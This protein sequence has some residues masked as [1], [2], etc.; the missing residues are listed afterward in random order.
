MWKAICKA[1]L[2]V[3]LSG[4]GW[5]VAAPAMTA[6]GAVAGQRQ[7]GVDVYRGIPF[8]LPPL[9]A[10][11]WR[12]PQPV[13]AWQGVREAGKFAPACMQQGV[14]M[15]G[16]AAPTVSEDC[17]YLNIWAPPR[18]AGQRLPVIVWIHGGGYTNGS[19][20]MPLYHG[21]RLARKGVLVVTIAYRLGALGFLAHPALSAESPHRSSGNYGLMDQ[22][23]ALEWVQRN[24]AAFGGDPQR[25]TIAGQSAGAMAVSALLVSP[26]AKG[27]FQRAIAQSGGIFE[28]LQLA[29]GYLLANAER[30]GVAYMQALGATTP[31]AM[32]K[33]PAARLTGTN[34]VSHPVIDGDVLPLSPY[35]GYVRGRNHDVPLLIGSNSE[36]A[37][38]L[39]DVTAVRADRFEADITASFGALPVALL[40]AY[41]HDTDAQARDARLGFER[42]LR[43]GWDMWAWARLA[44]SGRSPVYY[45]SF[46]H[47]PPFP[48]GSVHAGWGAS[49]F[50]EMWYMFDHLGQAPWKWRA[51]DHALAAAMSDYWVRFAATGDPNGQGLPHWPAFRGAAGQVQRLGDPIGTGPVPALRQLQVFDAVYAKVRG[52]AFGD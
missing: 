38:A 13:P 32:R 39:V 21:D 43:F 6:Q 29:P 15:P 30:D 48:A 23:A 22:I 3:L 41:P 18:H 49:H 4:A 46:E 1:S 26:R 44:Q 10:L 20:S 35:D 33:L 2:A 28:P 9:G 19:A 34:P 52:S 31:D 11:R 8:A 16:E 51:A 5:A 25:V 40:A 37:R 14:S 42:D 47:Q 24:I 7:A 36:E 12:P 50:A 45:Y 27:L 17:L